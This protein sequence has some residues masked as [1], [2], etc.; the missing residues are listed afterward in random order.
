MKFIFIFLLILFLPL[1]IFA[2]QP[3]CVLPDGT[4]CEAKY[5]FDPK[6][7]DKFANRFYELLPNNDQ[8]D[9]TIE[10][11][12]ELYEMAILTCEEPFLSMTPEEIGRNG[13]PFFTWQFTAAMVRAAREIIC[14]GKR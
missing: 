8:K 9:N 5:T 11:L 2:Q 4:A 6:T 12:K 10:N 1:S 13:E 3:K 14:P 7:I